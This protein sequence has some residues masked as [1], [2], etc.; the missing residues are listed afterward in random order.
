MEAGTDMVREQSAEGV[1]IVGD[2]APLSPED[3]D[4]TV[5]DPIQD[6]DDVFRD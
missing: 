3:L 6:A 4:Y 2:E 1:A 5:G